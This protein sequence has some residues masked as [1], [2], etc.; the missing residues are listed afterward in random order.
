MSLIGYK[1]NHLFIEGCLASD[2]AKKWGTPCYVYSK[3]TLIKAFQ[4]FQNGLRELPHQI[5]YALKAN[6]NLSLLK[7]LVELGSGFDIVS[8]G[9]LE[10]ALKVGAK[11]EKIVFSG[12]G[13]THSA[14]H[15][16]L[17]VGIGCFN[18][19]SFSE[20]KRIHA[21]AKSLKKTAPIAWR[22]N[23]DIQANTHPY[24]STGLKENKFG[25]SIE[26]AKKL[27]DHLNDMPWVSLVGL[28]CHLGSQIVSLDPFV[29]AWD[30]LLDFARFCEKK[31]FS[32]KT[33][34]VG[35]GLGVRYENENPPS[36]STYTHTLVEHFKNTPYTLIVEPG[37]S[38]VAETGIL[39]ASCEYIKQTENK[40]F[41]I[42][43][44]G[45]SELLRPALYGAW[46]PI[47]PCY[48]K[49]GAPTMLVDV[50]GPIC[51]SSD[52]LGLNRS[53][54]CIQEGDLIAIGMTGAYGFSMS[55][56]YNSR[57]RPPEIWVN[58]E[59]AHLIRKR[60]TIADLWAH[61]VNI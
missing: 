7:C 13:K 47:W 5:A 22:L 52:W 55:N 60:E 36:I 12:V 61:E 23:P 25:L 4:D 42:L 34:D 39:L 20:L 21:I 57:P 35:G 27:C 8:E 46:Q 38:L 51:E 9:E 26:E 18:V 2:I 56:Q 43:D 37:R 10:R 3:N 15:R 14:I 11:P 41:V 44:T 28:D 33:I 31:G 1:N 54:P 30:V 50:V 19:E 16:S 17:E 53:L 24:I 45:L 59:A 6:N 48:Q 40:T 49:E 58:G 32:I 29:A